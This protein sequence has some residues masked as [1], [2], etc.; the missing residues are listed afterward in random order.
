VSV[1]RVDD[2]DDLY[3]DVDDHEHDFDVVDHFD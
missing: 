2:F 1:G 3:H